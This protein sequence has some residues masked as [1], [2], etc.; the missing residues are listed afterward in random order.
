M[1]VVVQHYI[2]TTDEWKTANPKLYEA[3]WGFEKTADGKVLAKLGN[4]RDLWNDLKYFDVEN[5]HGLPELLQNIHNLIETET[6][7]RKDAD[8]ALTEA[9]DAEAQ[10]RKDADQALAEAIDAEA[11]ERRDAD[12]ALTEA[13]DAETQERKEADRALAEAIDAEAKER[14][15]AD[16]TLAGAIDAEAQ[17]RK[18][19]DRALTE[20]IDTE[21]QERKDADKA[22]AEAIDAEAQERR[23]ADQALTEAIDAETQERKDADRALAE[24]IDAEAQERRDADQA[25]T[26]AIDAETQERKDA[27][28]ALA[29]AID[30]EAQERKDADNSLGEA[31][32]AETQGREQGDA[33]TLASA[34]AYT[35]TRLTY[36]LTEEETN[37]LLH[38][39]I[40]SLLVDKGT[41]SDRSGLPE[42]ADN[43]D[44]YMIEDEE[45]VVFA[46]NG[47]SGIVWLPLGFFADMTLYETV[48]GATE[49][50][51]AAII[52]AKAY[53]DTKA[54]N[55]VGVPSGGTAGQ[56]LRKRSD[57]DFDTEWG[58]GNG[59][60]GGGDKVPTPI[61]IYVTSLPDKSAYAVGET[62]D[63][64]GLT[65]MAIFSD[66]SE[67]VIY[68]ENP[69]DQGLNG[70]ILSPPDMGSAGNKPVTVTYRSLTTSF[71]ITVAAAPS[72]SVLTGI[73]IAELPEKVVYEVGENLDISGI[74]INAVFSNGTKIP[75]TYNANGIDGYK[76]SSPDMATVG[77]KTVTVS[78]MPDETAFTQT[79]TI[80]VC[81]GSDWDGV[82]DNVT[83]TNQNLLAVFGV[84]TAQEAWEMSHQRINADGL[85]NYHGM[86]LGDYIDI[87][88][89]LPAPL[90]IAWNANYVNL[91]IYILG[92]NIYKGINGNTKNNIL[93][94]FQNIPLTRQMNTSSTNA[95]GYPASDLKEF[96]DGDFYTALLAAL[97]ADYFYNV[98]RS[99]NNRSGHTVMQ[100]KL[101]LPN[102]SEIL[103]SASGDETLPHVE[104]PLYQKDAVHRRKKFDGTS[105]YWWTGSPLLGSIPQAS[106]NFFFANFNNTGDVGGGANLP[107]NQVLG[108]SPH[109][110]QI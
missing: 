86:G 52:E 31:L 84:A 96:I 97:G 82:V 67:A 7:E 16:Q 36:Y 49:K 15:D 47:S 40:G 102:V 55:G 8:Q 89:G 93:W 38:E 77:N 25:L 53:T 101:W 30:A 107:A 11:K 92:F 66:L 90:N 75:L 109:F 78:Y 26:E 42:E 108:V 73:E 70:Y 5:I 54:T 6:Q 99:V 48:S 80:E 3:V 56:I 29:E 69:P 79:Y 68:P 33:D 18:D 57:D 62:F 24:A 39:R 105:N 98:V 43:F 4:G 65:V 50:M 37:L 23:D 63:P 20:A 10:E 21:A 22:L 104:I 94:G 103:S 28:Q 83:E 72:V 87:T 88:A 81:Y 2:G 64:T 13:I 74:V 76:C 95:G 9:I 85:S 32:E 91:R 60:G 27:D 100:A 35:N 51:E 106:T 110:C 17:E 44:S 41:V 71:A 45:L 19:A 59:T 12:Q 58:D 61:A 34:K 1:K 46:Y 14:K